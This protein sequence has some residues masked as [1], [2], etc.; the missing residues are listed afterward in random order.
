MRFKR[1]RNEHDFSAEIDAHLELEADRLEEQGLSRR[2]ALA[3]ARRRFG[4]AT[5]VREQFHEARAGRIRERLGQDL[6]F[7]ARMLKKHPG[8]TVVAV[9]TLALALGINMAVFSVLDAAVMRALPVPHP[10]RLVM[11]TDPNASLILGGLVAGERSLLAYTEFE[12]LRDGTKTLSGLCAAQL[13]FNRWQVRISGEAP[14]MA[15]GRLVSENYFSTLEV[16]PALGRLFLQTDA[17]GVGNDP[18]AVISYDYWQQRFGGNPAVVGTRL[19]LN[20]AALTI[21]GVTPKGFHGE[22]AGQRPD[23]WVPMLMQPLATP[24]SDGLSAMMPGS[25]HDK[26][27]W[28]QVFGRRKPGVSLAQVQAEMT[29]LFRGILQADYAASGGAEVRNLALR[30]YMVVKP[31]RAG[32]FHGRKE[33]AQQWK[34]LLALAAMI[35]LA[36]CANVAHLLLARAAGR[37]RE[38]AIRLSLGAA[39]GRLF[40]QLMTEHLLL[41][42]ISGAAGLVVAHIAL[43]GLLRAVEGGNKD[44]MLTAGLDPL[45]LAFGAVAIAGGGVL[46]G[47]VPAWRAASVDVHED[48]KRSGRAV[49]GSRQHNSVARWLVIAQMALSF[50]LVAGAGLFLHS[51]YNLQAVTLGY[52][53]GNLLLVEVNSQD[54]GYEGT[55]Q[56]RL[57]RQLA[58]AIRQIPGVRNA[59]YSGRGLFSGFEG[60]FPVTVEGFSSRREADRGSAGDTVGPEYFSTVGVPLVSGRPLGSSDVLNAPRVCVVNQAFVRQFFEGRNPLGRSVKTILPDAEG[61][62]APRQLQVVG[63]S[64][65]VR[66]Q[67][68]RGKIDAKFYVAG[69]GSWLEIR[70][71][72]EAA[73][74]LP[75]VRK[76]IYA[77][78]ENLAISEA[79][80]LDQTIAAEDAPAR[81]IAQLATGFGFL[82]LMLAASGVYGLL[83]YEIGRRRH[84]IGIRLAVGARPQQVMTMLFRETGR[85][86]ALGVCAGSAAFALGARLLAMQWAGLANSGGRWSLTRYQQVDDATRLFGVQVLDPLT[87]AATIA[88]LAGVALAATL[89]PAVQAAHTHPL[90]ALGDE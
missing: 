80:T 82:A 56:E 1:S 87:I 27:M 14:E 43:R 28:L 85:L 76:A 65:D 72:T 38:M 7:G 70:T 3:E 75:A 62:S 11:L 66:A 5:R 41:G 60:A 55:R 53:R 45:V 88:V 67:S 84:E 90:E 31:A 50:L 21:I 32:A 26:L 24:G 34:L 78:D 61:Q 40:C 73:N 69:S 22:T 19:R 64:R 16:R 81:L 57:M 23:V 74:L 51:L 2:E 8:G 17:R 71:A 35:L 4:N 48:L 52:P 77:R 33:F 36:A 37:S 54:A 59:S 42:L 68:L 12:R 79:K 58:D 89:A 46:F 47:V 39:R 30:Q 13:S 10:E 20:R 44:F 6:R 86:V 29:V 63:V 15:R 83:S 25:D 18:Y 9:L 49:A